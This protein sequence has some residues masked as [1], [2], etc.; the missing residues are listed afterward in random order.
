VPGSWECLQDA[1][2]SS[3]PQ[4]IVIGADGTVTASALPSA[5]YVIATGVYVVPAVPAETW[6]WAGWNNATGILQLRPTAS[7]ASIQCFYLNATAPTGLALVDVGGQA[8]TRD[9]TLQCLTATYTALPGVLTAPVCVPQSNATWSPEVST[10]LLT[11][12]P[13][14]PSAASG[15]QSAAS[16]LTAVAVGLAALAGGSL[17]L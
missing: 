14:G 4:T 11:L 8:V 3:R 5:T 6:L 1:V 9:W 17:I 16:M 12:S 10:I 15:A 13:G 2:V 7:P